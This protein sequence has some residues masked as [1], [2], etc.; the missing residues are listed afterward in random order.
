MKRLRTPPQRPLASYA[1]AL[2]TIHEYMRRPETRPPSDSTPQSVLV[3]PRAEDLPG[4]DH[5]HY[6]P[7]SESVTSRSSLP[8]SPVPLRSSRRYR[9]AQPPA[10]PPCRVL[11]KG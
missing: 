7:L 9:T 10:T 3:P 8:L 1:P 6:L 2:Q 5:Q 11:T 4:G